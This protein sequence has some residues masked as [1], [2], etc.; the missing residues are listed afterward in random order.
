ML[1]NLA[2]STDGSAVEEACNIGRSDAIYR[3]QRRPRRPLTL[4]RG[5]TC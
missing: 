1:L 2:H 3:W 4:D 5:A